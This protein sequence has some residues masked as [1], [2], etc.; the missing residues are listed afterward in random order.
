[1]KR[2]WF[3]IS[4]VMAAVLA[5]APLWAQRGLG[6]G[7]ATGSV[8]GAARG[9]VNGT[10]SQPPAQANNPK[11]PSGR[12]LGQSVDG[13]LNVTQNA[14]LSSHLQPLLPNGTSVAN[15]A[16]GFEDQGEFISAVHVAH[17]LNIPFEQL[18]AQVTGKNSVSLGKAI[19][20]LRPDLD[21][22]AVKSNLTLAERQT[23]RDTQQAQ[24]AG[25]QDRFVTRL[26]SDTKLAARLTPLLPPGM[27]LA[28]AAAGFKNEGQFIAALHVA[29]SLN[30]PFLELKDRM[31]AGESLGAAIH[32][33]KPDL[34]A[35]EVE[36][37][38]VTADEESKNDRI[39]A[40]AS[41]SVSTSTSADVKSK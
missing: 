2:R 32:A 26:A 10:I 6:V 14:E 8:N 20:N 11:G 40:S 23:E 36:S 27:T 28:N 17:N 25:K 1:M 31:T 38:T 13:T 4:C 30:I 9:T 29:K 3:L 12:G 21:G 19:K 41:A 33:L 24:S 34:D 37:A 18:K 39:E 35:K 16:A 22:K 5:A 7:N 15:A